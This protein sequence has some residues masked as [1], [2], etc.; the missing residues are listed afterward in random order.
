MKKIAYCEVCNSKELTTVLNLGSYPLCDDLIP[1]SSMQESVE[2]PIEIL[3]CTECSTAHQKFQVPKTDLFPKNYHY[4]S[5]FTGDVVNGMKQLAGN[6]D[7]FLPQGIRG[8]TILDI[9]SNDGTLL[10]IFKDFQTIT[11]G[12][13]PTDAAIESENKGH[14]IYQTYFDKTVTE[15]IISKFGIPDVITFTN[16]FAHVDDLKTMLLCL[17]TLMGPDTLLVIENHYLGAVLSHMQ[18]D[19]F[20][21]EH[22]RTYSAKSFIYIAET[23]A[24]D[25]NLIEFPERYGGNIRVF[26]SKRFKSIRESDLEAILKS[27]DSFLERFIEMDKAIARYTQKTTILISNLVQIHGRLPAKAFPGRAA[28][29]VKMLNLSDKQISAVYEKPGS[30]KIGHYLPGSKIPILSDEEL[31]SKSRNLPIINLAW[32]ISPEI[33]DYLNSLGYVGEI[34]DIISAESFL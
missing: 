4:R 6:V 16:V 33:A 2:Y 18:F 10:D 11:I 29:L 1:I 12:I 20:Y 23:L 25:I 26:I 21:H 19:T 5:R 15:E 14:A 34:V 9:G 7:K 24:A 13:E 8:K 22:P 3:L 17:N 31:L 28:I 30:K 27:E 32:H